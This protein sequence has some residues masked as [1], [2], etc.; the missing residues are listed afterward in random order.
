MSWWAVSSQHLPF[1]LHVFVD[2][3][4]NGKGCEGIVPASNDGQRQVEQDS[5]DGEAPVVVL[6]AWP[7]VSCV[8]QCQ[9]GTCQVD[10]TIAHQE[11]AEGQ[12]Q[13]SSSRLC[14]QNWLSHALKQNHSHV[15]DRG[16]S[17][18]AGNQYTNFCNQSSQD[19]G[20]DWLTR[21]RRHFEDVQE[22]NDVIT[23]YGLQQPWSTCNKKVTWMASFNRVFQI[24]A[25]LCAQRTHCIIHA[26]D[27]VGM[28]EGTLPAFLN[29]GM[30]KRRKE[31]GRQHLSWML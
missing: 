2:E 19:Q 22:R 28:H 21:P 25:M 26:F 18:Q 11:E 31:H 5:Q 7:P 8:H 14:L 9:Q 27:V 10:K 20:P 6:E 16:H 12:K 3:G 29:R 23:S 24:Q 4:C 30:K 17:F 13:T 1:V 15:N